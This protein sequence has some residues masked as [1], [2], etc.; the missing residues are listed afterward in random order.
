VSEKA[1]IR[2]TDG[3]SRRR[4]KQNRLVSVAVSVRADEKL[5]CRVD[6]GSFGRGRDELRE[7]IGQSPIGGVAE[8]RPRSAR[9]RSIASSRRADARNARQR[10]PIVCLGCRKKLKVRRRWQSYSRHLRS[11]SQDPQLSFS[12]YSRKL[13]A[14]SFATGSSHQEGRQCPLCRRRRK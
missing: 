10:S 14:E 2:T 8:A 13:K 9:R 3:L 4:R 5:A 1:S 7:Q 11:R 6:T 12:Y